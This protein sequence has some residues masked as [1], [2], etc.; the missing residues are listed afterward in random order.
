MTSACSMAWALRSHA[1]LK[2]RKADADRLTTIVT[3][4]KGWPG[5]ESDRNNA[6]TYCGQR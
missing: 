4:V 3:V 5:N 6:N 1:Y 2:Q